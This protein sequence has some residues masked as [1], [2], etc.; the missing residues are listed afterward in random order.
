MKANINAGNIPKMCVG[1]GCVSWNILL[2]F[3]HY[4][5]YT[6]SNKAEEEQMEMVVQEIWKRHRYVTIYTI[7]VILVLLFRFFR[8]V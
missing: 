5:L 1:F 7:I 6:K 4:V 3:Q 2:L 8:V